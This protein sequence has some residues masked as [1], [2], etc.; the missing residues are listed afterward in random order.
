MLCKKTLN[1]QSHYHHATCPGVVNKNIQIPYKCGSCQTI[2]PNKGQLWVHL[3]KCKKIASTHKAQETIKETIRK[4]LSF[5]SV[6]MTT[7]RML[8]GKLSQDNIDIILLN[9]SPPW[10]GSFSIKKKG[11]KKLSK[12]PKPKDLVHQTYLEK[13]LERPVELHNLCCKEYFENYSE[14]NR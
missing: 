7:W 12:K 14:K 5:K 1:Q 13:W 2:C 3:I 11:L 9:I 6:M 10:W 4:K 8:Y